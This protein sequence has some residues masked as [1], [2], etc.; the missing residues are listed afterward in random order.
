MQTYEKIMGCSRNEVWELLK[1][2]DDEDCGLPCA[3]VFSRGK[4]NYVFD[5]HFICPVCSEKIV[6]KDRT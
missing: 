1:G 6:C 4:A 2:D 3:Y 5:G